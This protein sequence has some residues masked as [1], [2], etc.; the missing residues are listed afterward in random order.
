ML[1]I[2]TLCGTS[3]SNGIVYTGD[4]DNKVEWKINTLKSEFGRFM[5]Y[6][7]KIKYYKLETPFVLK[8]E[9]KKSEIEEYYN[10]C[11]EVFAT[12]NRT[13]I[14]RANNSKEHYDFDY[15][16]TGCDMLVNPE[17]KSPIKNDSIL[18]SYDFKTRKI[19]LD[20]GYIHIDHIRIT[21]DFGREHY[22]KVNRIDNGYTIEKNIQYHGGIYIIELFNEI[23][24]IFRESIAKG[25]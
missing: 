25:E 5:V 17:L 20:C 6:K 16:L 4:K 11:W 23:G 12:V 1:F 8:K 13:T 24:L 7:H 15:E 10:L 19:I 9:F 18:M 2:T 14:V 3:S 21:D 22:L